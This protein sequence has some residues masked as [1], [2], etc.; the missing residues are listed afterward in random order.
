MFIFLKIC[1]HIFQS[2][3]LISPKI[4]AYILQDVHLF[5][6]NVKVL[7]CRSILHKKSANG[8]QTKKKL[9]SLS[10]HL[11]FDIITVPSKAIF[12]S[13]DEFV[14]AC[15]IPRQV[16]L[17]DSLPLR[18]SL[19]VLVCPT[20]NLC[21]VQLAADF[22]ITFC[23]QYTVRILV[24]ISLLETFSSIKNQITLRCSSLDTLV[25]VPVIINSLIAT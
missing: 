8:P 25:G 15:G 18:I 13:I 4:C 24:W 20:L 6:Q 3:A 7:L 5:F 19:L 10:Y 22:V 12:V 16:L 23:T 11:F 21:T 17:F 9:Y 1:L 14:D 2:F